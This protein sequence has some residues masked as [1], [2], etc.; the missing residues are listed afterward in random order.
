MISRPLFAALLLA[1]PLRQVAAQQ[2]WQ[3]QTDSDG[4]DK[5]ST[6]LV[7]LSADRS[8]RLELTCIETPMA[9]DGVRWVEYLPWVGLTLD[10]RFGFFDFAGDYFVLV[11]AR[12]L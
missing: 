5:P 12:F 6:S 9:R 8:A 11:R 7:A 2:G 1:L 4:F 10:G 3:V